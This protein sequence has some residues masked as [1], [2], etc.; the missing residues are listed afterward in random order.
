MTLS[1]VEPTTLRLVAQC[2]KQLG[3]SVPQI[4]GVQTNKRKDITSLQ[5]LL[6]KSK[7]TSPLNIS[8]LPLD[9]TKE[10]SCALRLL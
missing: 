1:G 5:E 10:A 8:V 7:K 2:L 9:E 6:S 4:R 3:Y